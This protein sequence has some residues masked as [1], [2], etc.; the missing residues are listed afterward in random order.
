M[1]KSLQDQL[2]EDNEHS[3]KQ[4]KQ[5]KLQVEKMFD[6]GQT[7]EPDSDLQSLFSNPQAKQKRSWTSL[8]PSEKCFPRGDGERAQ[9]TFSRPNIDGENVR[10]GE[11]MKSM[12]SVTSLSNV[13]SMSSLSV[14]P[15]EPQPTFDQMFAAQPE[16]VRSAEY[17]EKAAKEKEKVRKEKEKEKEKSA[18]LDLKKKFTSL[19]KESKASVNK[20][21]EKKSKTKEKEDKSKEKEEKSKEK[22]EKCKEREKSKHNVKDDKTAKKEKKKVE[23]KSKS[24]PTSPSESIVP[25]VKKEEKKEE[26]NTHAKPDGAKLDVAVKESE[27]HRR[28]TSVSWSATFGDEKASNEALTLAEHTNDNTHKRNSSLSW[29]ATFEGGDEEVASKEKNVTK[30]EEESVKKEEDGKKEK[31]RDGYLAPENEKM[32]GS[33]HKKN[34]SVSWTAKFEDARDSGDKGTAKLSFSPDSKDEDDPT[35]LP[36]DL[37]DAVESKFVDMTRPVEE[38]VSETELEKGGEAKIEIRPDEENKEKE[39]ET[40][41]VSVKAKFTKLDDFKEAIEDEGTGTAGDTKL[42]LSPPHEKSEE[43]G[44]LKDREASV[45]WSAKFDDSEDDGEEKEV[46]LTLG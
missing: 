15:K 5:E 45:K 4:Q 33:R 41:E 23:K 14:V 3:R 26:K 29:K 40:S 30:K 46:P 9:S 31:K 19:R 20:K 27:G 44:E 1:P 18:P 16:M 17:D 2:R 42:H 6:N 36:V 10:S 37:G 43:H 12:T 24:R 32:E 11:N 7:A 21:E 13:K 34:A 39:D 8:W 35:A 22:E 28:N 38:N 25:S